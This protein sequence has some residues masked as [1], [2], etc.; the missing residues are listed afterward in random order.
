LELGLLE[1]EKVRI[2]LL[3]IVEKAFSEAGP[4]TVHIP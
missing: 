4:E 3:K 2:C 1:A